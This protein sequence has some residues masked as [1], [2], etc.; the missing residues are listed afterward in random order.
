M[1]GPRP[2]LP[3][4]LGLPSIP[5]A[6]HRVR[7]ARAASCLQHPEMPQG[8]PC[9]SSKAQCAAYPGR[10]P[11]RWM[12]WLGWSQARICAPGT[13]CALGGPGRPGI[14]SRESLSFPFGRLC[15]SLLSLPFLK[16]KESLDTSLI[17]AQVQ[18]LEE[19]G[20]P[21]EGSSVGPCGEEHPLPGLAERQGRAGALR[22]GCRPASLQGHIG[23]P[24]GMGHP[25]ARPLC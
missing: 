2:R 10:L 15:V 16:F 24:G 1:S 13:L 9:P 14:R 4:P 21:A 5:A 20:C 25:L 19:G 3:G 11:L 7:T 12:A 18:C 6:P 8:L 17:S 23:E 22:L